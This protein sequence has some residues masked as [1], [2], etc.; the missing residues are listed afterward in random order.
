[1]VLQHALGG[2]IQFRRFRRRRRA[3]PAA[4]FDFDPGGRPSTKVR[5]GP[6]VYP[7]GPYDHIVTAEGRRE[8]MM[9]TFERPDGGRGFGFTGGHKHVN[10]SDNNCR[11]VVLNAMLWIAKAEVP[12]NGVESTVR[13]EELAANLDPK[14]P[15]WTAP[16]LTG[17]WAC[18]VETDNGTGEPSFSFINAGQNLL[19]TYKGLLGEAAVYGEIGKT[20][21]VKF[22]FTGKR[23][24]QEIPVTY[25]GQ[26]EGGDAMKGK[27]QLGDLGTGTWTGQKK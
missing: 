12:A 14:K 7:Q 19:G 8:T 5:N 18:R 1:M 26:I 17:H 4:G 27:V 25:T 3:R 15:A 2:G 21:S 6:Y 16:N 24:D 9:W 13:P 20:N 23:E 22:W 11:K 10:W